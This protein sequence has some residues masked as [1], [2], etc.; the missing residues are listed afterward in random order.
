M[1]GKFFSLSTL[2][3]VMTLGNPEFF[4]N[5]GRDD[6]HDVRVAA[7]DPAL[8]ISSKNSHFEIPDTFEVEGKKLYG[9]DYDKYLVTGN[10]MY[11]KGICDGDY[12]LVNKNE[13]VPY[14]MGD[15]LI[16]RVDTDYYNKY[17]PKTVIYDFKL[18]RALM[19]I[20]ANMTVDEI[21]N[22]LKENHF[23]IYV[24]SNQTHISDK[25]RKARLAYPDEELMLSTTYHDGR[26][27]YSFHPVSLIVGRGSVLV[28]LK[29]GQRQYSFCKREA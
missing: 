2:E 14:Q 4:R 7:G 26:L 8:S 1:I 23:E 17:N 12:L 19:W 10:S 5:I 16:I 15:F 9:A 25:Y 18:R 27:R 21:V 24:E 6:C 3:K 20:S 22:R 13:K 29:D 28:S 11:P